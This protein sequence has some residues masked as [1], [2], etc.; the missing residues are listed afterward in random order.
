MSFPRA[1]NLEVLLEDILARR[2][3]MS[4]TVDPSLKLTPCGCIVSNQHAAQ[5]TGRV[6]NYT[7]RHLAR[8]RLCGRPGL[9]LAQIRATSIWPIDCLG[10][11]GLQFGDTRS[12]MGKV[13]LSSPDGS[14]VMGT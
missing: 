4:C 10:V 12:I 9:G 13:V 2:L 8:S 1:E 11:Y 14:H 7:S 5:P 6:S 3:S